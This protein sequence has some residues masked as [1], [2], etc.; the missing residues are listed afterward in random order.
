MSRAFFQ[1]LIATRFW[2]L[3]QKELRQILRDKQLLF[4]LI[5]PPTFQL[6]IFGFA[7]SPVV[8]HLKLAVQDFSLTPTSREL[9]SAIVENHVF[10][11]VAV[12]NS[13]KAIIGAVRDGKVDASII[14][15]PELN[16]QIQQRRQTHV[17]VLLNGVDA[18]T[19]GIASGYIS[20]IFNDFNRKLTARSLSKPVQINVSFL[21]NPG[22]IS[23]WFFVPGVM[24]LV[25]NLTGSLVSS[26]TLVR[27]KDS[28]TL[29]Q[30]L[31]TPAASWEILA[32]KITP[33]F[34]LLNF[35]VLLALSV[36]SFIF[37]LPFRGN[38]FLYMAI[39]SLYIFVAI[40]IGITL[41]TIS[42]NQRQAVL[43]SFFFNL[44]IIQLSG[45]VAP[46]ES[47]PQ[48]FQWL[49]ILNP[50]RYY[51]TCIRAIILRGVGLEVLWP[52]VLALAFFALVLLLG[53]ASQF[54][55]QLS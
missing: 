4:L 33:L 53:S 43:T 22:L 2:A 41:A 18:N 12:G 3:A 20:Q 16:R 34:F 6:F 28:G 36:G 15:P 51:V 40:S 48:F 38:F 1:K 31:M 39:S 24:G 45:A 26:S 49:S 10:D 27:E 7:L 54:R 13:T 8:E 32:A 11:L 46:I 42:R 17:Q 21:Y 25:L 37:G 55:R 47:M 30:L 14:I 35:E 19:A 9:V 52:N 29:E 5:F 44:P 23:A 50:L